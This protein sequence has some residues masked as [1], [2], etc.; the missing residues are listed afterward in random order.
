MGAHRTNRAVRKT[1]RKEQQR[2]LKRSW[3]ILDPLS[4]KK[5]PYLEEE[6]NLR[7]RNKA[8]Q[9]TPHLGAEAYA[10]IDPV[11]EAKARGLFGSRAR[12]FIRGFY[13]DLSGKHGLGRRRKTRKEE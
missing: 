3:S 13:H 1:N 5:T 2:Q 12:P 6:D 10:K 11:E 9:A 7:A 8:R 4:K